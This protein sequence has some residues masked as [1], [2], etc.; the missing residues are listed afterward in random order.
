VDAPE[1]GR[2]AAFRRA[3]VRHGTIEWPGELDLAPE[4]LIW[5][6]NPIDRSGRPAER[7]TLT[8]PGAAAG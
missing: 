4:V 7:M 3:R 1:R 6:P 2:A 8:P 5:G